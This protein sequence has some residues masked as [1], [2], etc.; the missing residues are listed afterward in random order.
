M[1]SQ[2]T[3]SEVRGMTSPSAVR[4]LVRS[5]RCDSAICVCVCGPH[6]FRADRAPEC[7]GRGDASSSRRVTCRTQKRPNHRR[8]RCA[9]QTKPDTN[10]RERSDSCR[11]KYRGD[12][13]SGR[14]ADTRSRWKDGAAR[15][16]HAPRAH[17]RRPREWRHVP[18][19]RSARPRL[20]LAF[21]RHNDSNSRNGSS[22]RRVEPKT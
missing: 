15:F 14:N 10:H 20:Y 7:T 1:R 13:D 2:G 22:I 18:R 17:V 6:S 11:R 16:R 3:A 21:G 4:E 19:S 8:Y 9:R 5:R 12:R